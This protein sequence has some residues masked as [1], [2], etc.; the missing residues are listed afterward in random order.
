[1]ILQ[2]EIRIIHLLPHS[3]DSG[4]PLKC[5][6]RVASL[7]DKPEYEALSYVWGDKDNLIDIQVSDLQVGVTENLY[8]ALRRLRRADEPRPLWVDQLCINQWDTKEKE[9]QVR[10]MRHIYT[11]CQTCILWMGDIKAGVTEDD[12]TS[13]LELIKYM[14]AAGKAGSDE[15]IPIP[16]CLDSDASFECTVRALQ[17]FSIVG[18]PWWARVWTVQEAVLPQNKILLWGPLAMTWETLSDATASWV[19]F[20]PNSIEV[21]LHHQWQLDIIGSLMAN[22]VWLDIAKLR[23]DPPVYLVNRWRFREATDPRDKIYAL[24]GLCS[25]GFMPRMESCNY[26]MSAMDVFCDLTADL[27]RSEED[28]FPLIMDP[29]LEAG[30]ATPGIPRWALDVSHI[31]EWNTDWFHLYAW[32]HYN[33]HGERSLDLD[34]VLSKWEE[35]RYTLELEGVFVD[36]IEIVGEPSVASPDPTVNQLQLRQERVRSWEHLAKQHVKQ[37]ASDSS[38]PY[39]GGYTLREAFGRLILG[40]LLRNHEQAVVAPATEVDVEGAYEFVDSGYSFETNRTI[41]GMMSNQK[42]FITKKGLMGIGHMDTQLG[43]EVWVFHGGNFPF[44]VIP[45]EGG[46]KDSYDFG[47]RCYVQGLMNGE[48]FEPGENTRILELH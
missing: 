42:F 23:T 10:L 14:A 47:G 8:S 5:E 40:D 46:N 36:T 25:T 45:R 1:M 27:L 26:D 41:Q 19:V 30:K 48:A 16:H 33:A 15:G 37:G 29:R 13:V 11:Q 7:E 2:N 9:Q 34:K 20:T 32:Q 39:P 3:G 43:E 12:A 44:T 22:V 35:T 24:M 21:R 6:L 28:L 18:N 17:A 38:E 4:A 31:S